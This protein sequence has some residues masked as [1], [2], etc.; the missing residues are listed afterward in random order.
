MRGAVGE[1]MSVE[2]IL[3]AVRKAIDEKWEDG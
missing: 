3:K 2:P 1:S